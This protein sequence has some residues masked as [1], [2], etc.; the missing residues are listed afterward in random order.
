[1]ININKCSTYK[2]KNYHFTM[3]MFTRHP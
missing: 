1:M 2:N 3:T